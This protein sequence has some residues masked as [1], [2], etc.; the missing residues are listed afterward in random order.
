MLL[1][2]VDFMVG[3]GGSGFW[4]GNSPT[5]SKVSGFVDGDSPPTVG[6][7]GSGG[8][9]SVSG[10]SGEL[11]RCRGPMDTPMHRIASLKDRN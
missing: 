4:G 5:D 2:F 9:S 8:G 1:D 7:V 3:S 10:R 11:I 6:L